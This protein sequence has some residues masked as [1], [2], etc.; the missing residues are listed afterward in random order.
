MCN[1]EQ[2]ILDDFFKDLESDGKNYKLLIGFTGS[3]YGY[4]GN[5]DFVPKNPV[6]SK[7]KTKSVIDIKKDNNKNRLF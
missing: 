2:K 5:F 3:D 4:T 6:K 1:D 7:K